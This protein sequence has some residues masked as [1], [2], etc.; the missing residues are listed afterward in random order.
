MA[1]AQTLGWG[2][3]LLTASGAQLGLFSIAARIRALFR[4]YSETLAR[5]VLLDLARAFREAPTQRSAE[6]G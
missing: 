4:F 1:K 2:L 6:K 3:N 5:T